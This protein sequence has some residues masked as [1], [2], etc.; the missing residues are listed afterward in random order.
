MKRFEFPLEA[1]LEKRKREEEAV[2]LELAEK[3]K[4]ILAA[5]NELQT[6][7]GELKGLQEEEKKRREQV[8]DVLPL[9]M[10]VSYRNKLKLDMLKKGEDIHTLQMER[11]DIR[12]KLVKATQRKRALELLRENRYQEWLKENK[13]LEQVFLDD[14]SQQ[15]FIRKK[16][17]AKRKK[18]AAV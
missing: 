8:K 5:Q 1:L 7:E 6:I 2:K 12:K 13:R 11:G 3:N 16:R 14:V 15:G 9:K 10:S 18:P 4:E 17:S